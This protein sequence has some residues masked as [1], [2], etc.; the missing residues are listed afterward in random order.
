MKIM[1]KKIILF[2]PNG[3][4]GGFIKEA[5][6]KEKNAQLYEITRD[7]NLNEYHMDY[8]VLIYSAAITSSRHET[9]DR[10]VQDN[11]VTAV[12]MIDFCKKHHIKRIIYLSSDEIYG[13]LNTD[14]VTDKTIMINPN[15]YATTKYLAEMIIRE[16]GI[17]YYILRLPAVV[18]KVWG[19]NF[20]YGLMDNLK[21]NEVV[22]LYNMDKDFNNIVDIDDLI[23]FVNILC[24]DYEN[25]NNEIFLLGNTKKMKLGDIARHIKMMYKSSS[26]IKNAN[27]A[28]NR[29]FT[30][31]VSR[32]VE[33]GYCSK[34]IEYIISELYQIQGS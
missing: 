11:V 2:S 24:G 31:D 16:C 32:A 5:I 10:Y 30:L 6:I 21:K 13:E 12:H 28:C 17:P 25:R 26:I 27:V 15:L 34:E 14:I 7:S 19:K 18:G 3:Y 8:D 33:Y 20:F 9:V 4:V 1:E 22:E 23:Q 29:Y